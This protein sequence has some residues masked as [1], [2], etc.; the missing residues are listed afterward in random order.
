MGSLRWRPIAGLSGFA[1]QKG[2][3]VI[4]K[5][6]T[7][8]IC[9]SQKRQTNHW[10]VAYEESGELR[11]SGW[12]SLHLL[13]PETKHLCGETCAQAY[14]PI[15]NEIGGWRDATVCRQG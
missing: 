4:R 15:P 9:G 7:C 13:S 6:I 1:L 11:I 5:V 12:N 8:D 14:Q 10:F 2:A 3:T